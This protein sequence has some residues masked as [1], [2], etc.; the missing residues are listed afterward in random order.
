MDALD[1]LLNRASMPLLDAPGPTP[2]Q[3]DIMFKA[4]LRAPDHGA[5]RPWRFL[6]I[7]GD[8]RQQL[9]Q[10]FLQAA[11]QDDPELI[12]ARQSKTLNMPLR[13]PTLIV[14]IASTTPEHKV[15][16]IEQQVSAGCAAQNILHAAH[17]QGLGA[18]WRTG[19][20]S[21]HPHVLEGLGLT[22]NEQLIGYLYLGTPTRERSAPEL[23]VERFVSHWP[24]Q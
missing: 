9:G 16:V 10:L 6:V 15:P 21:Y 2:E 18:M 20:M 3:L 14:V 5:L 12:D 19:A 22:E 23:P 17:I 11:L 24:G 7:E 4:A 13:A 8:A 1:A